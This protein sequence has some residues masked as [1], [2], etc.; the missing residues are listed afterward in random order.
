MTAPATSTIDDITSDGG[1]ISRL[2]IGE[3]DTSSVRASGVA[4]A[5][6]DNP[7]GDADLILRSSQ[8]LDFY[9]HK[10]ILR[11][12]SE[13]FATMLSLPQPSTLHVRG[14]DTNTSGGSAGDSS[15]TLPVVPVTE[16]D[17]CLEDVLRLCYPPAIPKREFS[18]V[19]TVSPLLA[20]A[21]KYQ[22]AQVVDNLTTQLKSFSSSHPLEVY[23]EAFHRHLDDIAKTAAAD[24]VGS[25]GINL[26]RVHTSISHPLDSYSTRLDDVP[27]SWYCKLLE[28]RAKSRGSMRTK[29]QVFCL[30]PRFSSAASCGYGKEHGRDSSMQPSHRFCDPS[31]ADAII[32]SSDGIDFFVLRSFLRY[33]SAVFEEI[34]A[35]SSSPTGHPTDSS[36]SNRL[37]DL[38]EDG[39]ILALLF[40]LCYPMADPELPDVPSD[41]KL[42]HL[43][44]LIEAGQKYKVARAVDFAKRTF[45]SEAAST[46]P[47]RLY[48]IASQQQ[49]EDGMEE[50]AI[51]CV[52]ELVDQYAPEMENGS[53]AAYRRLLV[54]R[55]KCRGIILARYDTFYIPP[56]TPPAPYWSKRKWLNEPSDARFWLAVHKRARENVAAGRE[57][58]LDGDSLFPQ[59]LRPTAPNAEATVDAT[60]VRTGI[61]SSRQTVVEIAKALVEVC[62][63]LRPICVT[64]SSADG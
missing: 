14:P 58:C 29:D 64:H 21:Q 63:M 46:C 61:T 48:F 62:T 52:Y 5:P 57:P 51:R 41:N 25:T 31:H 50:A 4:A 38:P 35:T 39:Q 28:Y 13:F 49:W 7:Y 8:G 36:S 10:S 26:N 18:N 56:K 43:Y 15:A 55:R 59:Y 40:Q 19:A 47:L 3:P 42:H 32:R 23:A 44:H 22:M 53:T 9:V 60:A 1:D 2:S 27:A 11:I 24:F 37:L 12:A 45:I 34:L 20:A 33:S 30:P 16:D 17:R 6:F 54:Y